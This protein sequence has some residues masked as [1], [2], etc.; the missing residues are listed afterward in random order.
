MNKKMS[1][2]RIVVAVIAAVAALP[3]VILIIDQLVS[4][5]RFNGTVTEVTKDGI[6]R[7][8]DDGTAS[9]GS[10]W[11]A[12]ILGDAVAQTDEYTVSTGFFTGTRLRSV[13]EFEAV[14][15]GSA[16][17]LVSAMHTGD[18]QYT[19]MYSVT[20]DE[21]LNISYEFRSAD[22]I[23]EDIP[24]NT[25]LVKNGSETSFTWQEF[26]AAAAYLC[27]EETDFPDIAQEELDKLTRLEFENTVCYFDTENGIVCIIK[28]GDRRSAYKIDELLLPMF[29]E[30][31]G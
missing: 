8:T 31:F 27:G 7:V 24:K 10:Y 1:L 26:K 25:V 2:G 14:K 17:V 18:L 4:V 30:N 22:A 16:L 28:N 23:L 20:V 3:I 13:F 19:N 5:H 29:K 21:D 12:E 9:M 11:E 6:L 15:E